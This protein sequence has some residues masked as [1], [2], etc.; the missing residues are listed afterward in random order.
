MNLM[1]KKL[2]KHYHDYNFRHITTLCLLYNKR[3]C[4]NWEI[5]TY[6]YRQDIFKTI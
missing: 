6:E 4:L 2:K 1:Y 3:N 5:R